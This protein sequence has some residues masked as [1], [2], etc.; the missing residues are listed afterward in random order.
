MPPTLHEGEI[1]DSSHNWSHLQYP[2]HPQHPGHPQA[3]HP[4]HPNH[5]G[6]YP[7]HLSHPQGPPPQHPAYHH[8][9]SPT[10]PPKSSPS[11]MPQQHRLPH[12][13]FGSMHHPQ[14][15]HGPIMQAGPHGHSVN[16]DERWDYREGRAHHPD[17][18]RD[19]WGPGGGMRTPSGPS[20]AG[21]AGSSGQHGPTPPPPHPNLH[22]GHPPPPHPQVGPFFVLSSLCLLAYLI[23]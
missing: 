15:P 5:P 3:H 19:G 4:S 17:V 20:S 12:P 6:H 14:N 11:F 7:G 18:R 13:N 2:S 9:L 10:Q 23:V 21:S 1:L 22:N 16:G 8:P